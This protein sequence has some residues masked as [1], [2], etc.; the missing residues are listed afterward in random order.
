METSHDSGNYGSHMVI[1]GT[2]LVSFAEIVDGYT[3]SGK[4][5]EKVK[6]YLVMVRLDCLEGALLMGP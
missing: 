6:Q 2:V 5:S 4:G 1:Q 3:P